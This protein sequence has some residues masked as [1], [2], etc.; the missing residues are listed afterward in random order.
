MDL[1][2]PAE[3]DLALCAICSKHSYSWGHLFPKSF[4]KRV[5]SQILFKDDQAASAWIEDYDYMIRKLSY[6]S[7]GRRVLIKSP[8]DTARISHLIRKYPDAKFI[9]I[10]RD[11]VSVYH[12]SEYLWEVIQQQASVQELQN[13]EIQ[14]L[15]LNTY[16]LLLS[17]YLQQ[18]K[19]IP[20]A[21]LIE[22]NYKNLQQ[23]LIGEIRK[24]YSKLE[25]GTPPEKE[26]ADFLAANKSYTNKIYSTSDDLKKMLAA[27]W[28]F[29]FEEWPD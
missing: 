17:N 9:F 27:K 6:R 25:L 28:S 7:K 10:F 1:D 8:G 2:L 21:Q 3:L 4:A 11:P 12:S 23:D 24:I 19:E 15:I 14:D 26:L 13:T 22:V 20:Q 5:D 29:A 18:R 16:E